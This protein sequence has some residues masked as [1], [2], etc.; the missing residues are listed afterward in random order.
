MGWIGR[1]RYR[2]LELDLT[3]DRCKFANAVVLLVNTL[4]RDKKGYLKNDGKL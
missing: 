4:E 1:Y 2:K 3:L